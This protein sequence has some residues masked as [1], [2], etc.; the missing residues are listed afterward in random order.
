MFNQKEA[1]VYFGIK[2]SLRLRDIMRI[3]NN[4]KIIEDTKSLLVFIIT[5][6]VQRDFNLLQDDNSHKNTGS[7]ENII[8]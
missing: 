5:T 6:M 4:D 8:Y 1:Y 3:N 2:Y 7:I